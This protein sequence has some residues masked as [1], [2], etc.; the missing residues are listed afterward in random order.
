M[1][2]LKHFSLLCAEIEKYL[3]PVMTVKNIKNFRLVLVQHNL[4]QAKN[5]LVKA[6]CFINIKVISL[7]TQ[8]I[9]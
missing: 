1:F 3:Q 9:V 6:L 4:L 5:F 8:R 2:L 7:S